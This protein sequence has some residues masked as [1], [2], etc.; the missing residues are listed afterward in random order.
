MPRTKA[1]TNQ[2]TIETIKDDLRILFPD[3][4]IT[5]T[6]SDNEEQT[7][8]LTVNQYPSKPVPPPAGRC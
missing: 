2:I 8:T 5:L 3:G 6:V 7:H 4:T 1:P